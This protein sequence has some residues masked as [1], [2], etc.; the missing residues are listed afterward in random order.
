MALLVSVSLAGEEPRVYTLKDC[1][2]YA[3]ESSADMRIRKT[4]EDD[5]RIARRD[6]ILQA[7]TPQVSAYAYAYSNFGRTVDPETNTYISTTSFNNAYSLSAGIVLFDGFSAVNNMRIA[8]TAQAMGYSK[9][10]QLRD[11]ICLATMEAYCNVVYYTR[12]SEII[13]AQVETASQTLDLVV[14]QEE[15]GIKGYADVVQ[16][17]ADAADMEYRKVEAD[18][19]LK[20]AVIVL[21]DVMFWPLDEDLQI[22][23]SIA[24]GMLAPS[25][26]SG[27][28]SLSVIIETAKN[29]VPALQ[30]A[31]GDLQTAQFRLNTARWQTVPSLSISGGWS[32]SYY[33]YPGQKGYVP[34][35]FWT[36]FSD[37]SGRYLQ[38]SLS[39]PIFDRLSRRSDIARKRN[40]Y[41]RAETE[42]ERKEREVEAEVMRAVQDRDG[43]MAAFMQADKRAQ[44]QKEAF[45][46][47]SKKLEQGL[48]SAIEYKT[49]SEQYLAAMA[50]R[51][52]ALLKYGIKNRVVA[53]YAGTGYLQQEY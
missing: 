1:M 15:L 26:V 8:R 47:N 25:G 4:E 34:T 40:E 9:E 14:R 17:R 12:L 7:F 43:A 29:N 42:L 3:V 24:D 6:A 33:T 2:E 16:A 18:N 20:D 46:L 39:I 22:D 28:D 53:Y 48:I 30:I 32:T 21:K 11:K 36:Q 49:S 13:G 37:N 50:E 23:M 5:E 10:A 38:L 41:V 27:T 19:N 52:N 35:P 44:V 51:L 45:E 31:R